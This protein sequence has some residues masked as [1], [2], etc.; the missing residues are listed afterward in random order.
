MS[1]C[2]ETID[3][4]VSEMIKQGDAMVKSLGLPEFRAVNGMD[5]NGICGVIYLPIDVYNQLENRLQQLETRRQQLS[6][7]KKTIEV[8]YPELEGDGYFVTHSNNVYTSK[9]AR[10]MCTED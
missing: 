6:A 1:Q 10:D 4:A 3:A 2:T 5:V 7:G 8:D 9:E